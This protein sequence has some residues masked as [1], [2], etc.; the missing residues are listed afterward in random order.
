MRGSGPLWRLMGQARRANLAAAGAPSPI[1]VREGVTRRRALA[2]LGAAA[3]IPLVG[4]PDAARAGKAGSGRVVVIG[5]GLAGL[6]AL[7]ELTANGIDAKLYEARGRLGGRVL[8]ANNA[9][10]PGLNIED[11]GNLINTD[12]ADML[13]LAE[14]F[15]IPLIDRKPMPARTRYVVDGT[16]LAE[17][18]LVAMLRPIAGQ[19]ARDAEALDE[20]YDV[21]APKFDAMSVSRYLDGHGGM[22]TPAVRALLDATI[23]TEFGAEPEQASAI[24]LLFNLPVVN[25]EAAELISLSDER[26][27]LT[28]GSSSVVNALAGPLM[29]RIA[30]GHAL[31]AIEPLGARVRLRFANGTIDEADRV[32]VT[33]PAP[34]MRTIDYGDLLPESWRR[35]VAEID[36]GRNEKINAGYAARSWEPVTGPAGAA[37][38]VETGGPGVFSEFWDASSGQPG[39]AGVLTWFF[40]GD[41]VDALMAGE[42][43]AVLRRAEAAIA[44]AVPGLAAR[45][46]RRTAWGRDP[47]ARGGYSSF[48]PGQLTRFAGHFW[49]EEEGVMTSPAPAGP[50]VFAGEHLSDAFPGYMNGG[51]QT[52]R[53]AAQS[54]LASLAMRKAA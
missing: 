22:L 23:R 51:A 10:E 52:G 35:V 6:C 28:G 5:G 14:R 17:S 2:A 20:N 48:A 27:I 19:I 9:P 4:W 34:L 38:A 3:A 47:F 12:H 45:T 42:V 43:E 1:R 8:T 29:P 26:Y 37:W 50:I 25:G 18:D 16:V 40:G 13:K 31:T 39:D 15:G 36:C 53:L 44:P 32:I 21:M 49:L 41:Q 33:V 7:D 30:T 11:G 54:V 46:M 24:E